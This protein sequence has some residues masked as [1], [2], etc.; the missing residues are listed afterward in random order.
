MQFLFD[1]LDVVCIK[2]RWGRCHFTS[3][4]ATIWRFLRSCKLRIKPL[5]F[6][7]LMLLLFCGLDAVVIGRLMPLSFDVVDA[8]FNFGFSCHCYLRLLCRC[9]R[10]AL[11]QFSVI[12]L[13]SDKIWRLLIPL[14]FDGVDAVVILTY[15]SGAVWRPM[16]L[17][18]WGIFP[19]LFGW[20]M[21]RSVGGFCRC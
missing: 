1:D 15:F 21:L 9:Y 2:G 11:M 13:D 16:P 12:G 20:L 6:G 19:F 18:Y 10:P 14:S 8:V 4:A 17:L 3:Y 5:L 7:R